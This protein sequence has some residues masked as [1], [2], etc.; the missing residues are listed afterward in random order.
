MIS[1]KRSLSRRSVEPSDNWFRE[2]WLYLTV[3]P[4]F[5]NFYNCYNEREVLSL[6]TDRKTL[7]DASE[8]PIND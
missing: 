2:S 1:P 3:A 5:N 8:T 4:V 7:M 6:K